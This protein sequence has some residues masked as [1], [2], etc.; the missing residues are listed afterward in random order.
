MPPK[1]RFKKEDII[2]AAF[3]IVRRHGWSGLS[4][5][6]IAKELHSS[7][8]PIYS[9]LKSIEDLKEEIVKKIFDLLFSYGTTKRTGDPWVDVGIG[10]VL[11]AKEEKQLFRCLGDEKLLP[12]NRKYGEKYF[13][14]ITKTLSGYPSFQG[15]SEEEI[16][17]V[18]EMG[19]IF[20]FGLA[21]LVSNSLV[22]FIPDEKE[23][24]RLLKMVD[25]ALLK[26]FKDYL[27]GDTV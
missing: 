16:Y 17:K 9:H 3:N 7:T 13:R 25:H 27:K 24:P 14:S 26:G 4:A 21:V 23:I 19:F 22:P 2:E 15:L 10:Y 18:R 6:S 5:R 1:T 12:V 8:Q 20:A 11:F